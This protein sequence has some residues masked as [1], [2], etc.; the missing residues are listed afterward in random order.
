V[1]KLLPGIT[2]TPPGYTSVRSLEN[3]MK[4]AGTF[5]VN[6]QTWD[7]VVEGRYAIVGSPE[8]VFRQ[9]EEC[10]ARFGTGNLLGLFQLGTLPED[11]TR[12]NL[13]LFASEV[14]PRL[15][16]RFPVGHPVLEPGASEGAA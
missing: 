14:M 15:K 13:E 5:A 1:R 4:G 8:T 6:L 2:I 7:E 16:E 3:Q 11:E 12:R 10:L 9:L